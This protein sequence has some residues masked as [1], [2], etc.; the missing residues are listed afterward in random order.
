MKEHFTLRYSATEDNDSLLELDLSFDNPTD[1]LLVKRLQDW[2][3]AIGKTKIVVSIP[4]NNATMNNTIINN[5]TVID[6]EDKNFYD[7]D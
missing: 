5:T 2:L 4:V 3:I 6:K 7:V 1:E